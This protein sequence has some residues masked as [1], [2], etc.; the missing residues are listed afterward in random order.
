MRRHRSSV[1]HDQHLSLYA[2]SIK[3]QLR[4][5]KKGGDHIRFASWK[6][7]SIKARVEVALVGG[8]ERS[9]GAAR[10]LLQLSG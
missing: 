5:F 3:K 10:R 6:D 7:C 9:A 8:V 4:V 1:G 2:K